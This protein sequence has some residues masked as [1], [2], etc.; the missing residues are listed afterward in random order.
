MKK[1]LKKVFKN[2]LFWAYLALIALVLVNSGPGLFSKLNTKFNGP[3]HIK[4]ANHQTSMVE[5]FSR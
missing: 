5:F 1:D 4:A 3:F 2:E